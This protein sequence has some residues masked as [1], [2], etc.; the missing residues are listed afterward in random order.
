[1][2]TNSDHPFVWANIN[3]P[4]GGGPGGR[5][6]GN[7]GS[8]AQNIAL[9]RALAAKR[10][11]TGPQWNAL[12]QLWMRES[13]WRTNADNPSSS[14]Y[15]IPQ[16]LTSLHNL[17]DKY[18]SDPRTQILWGLNYIAGRYGNPAAAMQFWKKNNYYKSG[19]WNVSEDQSADIHQGE[20]VLS[21]KV[22]DAVRSE[23]TSTRRRGSGGGGGV[24]FQ[25]GAIV[26]QVSG[27]T[28]KQAMTVAG[29][30]IVDA[31]VEDSRFKAL[32]EGV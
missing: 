14:A 32:A 22:A 6:A 16:A 3:L 28:S 21:S 10:G 23:I 1:M 20:M 29:K 19:A 8:V 18:K 5:A 13:G 15:G 2:G 27:S 30:Q 31:M 17:G 26:V 4:G 12:Q 25:A 11:W 24:V 9:G 7:G